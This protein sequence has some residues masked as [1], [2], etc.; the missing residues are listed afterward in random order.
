[1]NALALVLEQA[2]RLWPELNQ[3]VEPGFAELPKPRVTPPYLR[4]AT[5]CEW[6]RCPSHG[7]PA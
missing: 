1:M 7:Q 4:E 5:P 2:E 3:P 6:F